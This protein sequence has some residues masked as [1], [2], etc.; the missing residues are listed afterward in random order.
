MPDISNWKLAYECLDSLRRS[1]TPGSIYDVLVRSDEA[2]Y[3][4][5]ILAAV[6]PWDNVKAPPHTKKGKAPPPFGTLAAQEGIKSP[7][8]L[9]DL[10]TAANNNRAEIM[11]FVTAVL[12]KQPSAMERDKLGMAIRHWESKNGHWRLQVLYALLVE[13]MVV[14]AAASTTPSKTRSN[15]LV[16]YAR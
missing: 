6:V 14:L 8:K 9:R 4:A 13:A 1:K 7:G 10:V 12:N 2:A 16:L 3:Y 11:S 15:N 5:W